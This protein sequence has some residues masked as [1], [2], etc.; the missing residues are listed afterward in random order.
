MRR[1][2]LSALE[3]ANSSLGKRISGLGFDER[4][5]DR[6]D[7]AVG[8]R[9]FTEVRVVDSLSGLRL[10]LA[11]IDCVGVAVDVCI[12]DQ[13]RHRDRNIVRVYS[14]ADTVQSQA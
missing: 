2:H 13:D 6:I 3:V 8:V 10:D 12:A 14:I 11:C 1:R 9:V 4:R 5:V 7:K